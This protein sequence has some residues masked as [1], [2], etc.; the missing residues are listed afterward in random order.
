MDKLAKIVQTITYWPVRFFLKIF[1]Q[2][3]IEG[4]ENLKGLENKA[5]IFAANHASFVDPLLAATSFPLNFLPIR[6]LATERLYKWWNFPVVLYLWFNGSVKIYPNPGDLFAS[7][8]KVLLLLKNKEKIL[9]F[10]EGKRTLDGNLQSGKRGVAFLH[11]QT[12]VLIVPLA[13][14]GTFKIFSFKN[15][16]GAKKVLVKIGKPIISLENMT[17]EQGTETVMQKIAELLAS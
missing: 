1:L 12:K 17:L 9:I 14:V 6:F 16:F 11:Q 10:P 4:L 7:L 15:L 13:L 3:Q 8:R 5:V 2:P